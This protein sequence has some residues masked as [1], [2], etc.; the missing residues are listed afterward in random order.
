[1]AT[2]TIADLETFYQVGVTEAERA[3]P[4]RLLVTVQL[5]HDLARAQSTDALADTIDYARLVDRVLQFGR[6]RQWAL[7]ETVAAD[8]ATMILEEFGPEAVA[9]EVKKFAI[10]QA[11]Y[12]SVRLER[13]K[14]APDAA[15][16]AS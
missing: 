2:I 10:P 5:V 12:V 8:L 16:P 14:A 7:I 11:R 13:R 6:G 15:A 1:M 9:V 4:Q 3:Q